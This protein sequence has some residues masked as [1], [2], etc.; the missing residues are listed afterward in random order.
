MYSWRGY[1]ADHQLAS[2]DTCTTFTAFSDEDV[3]GTLTLGVDSPE[4]LAADATFKQ[5]LDVFRSA[6][7]AKLCEL[8]TF[9]FSSDVKS[10]PALATLF[11]TIFI[12]EAQ[13]FGCTDVFIEVNPRHVRFYEVMLGFRCV[14]PPK[15]DATVSWWPSDL[16]VQLMRLNLADMRREIDHHAGASVKQ[17]RSLYPFFLSNHEEAAVRSRVTQVSRKFTGSSLA[18]PVSSQA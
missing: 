11:H 12:Y 14:G 3:I 10:K 7:E 5:E 4:G 18:A 13:Q 16:P 17:G 9:A 1:G 8:K 2:S 15:V 6:P